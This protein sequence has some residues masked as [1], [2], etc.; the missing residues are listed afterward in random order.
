MGRKKKAPYEYRLRWDSIVYTP[1]ELRAVAYKYGRYWAEGTVSTTGEP[2]RLQLQ[3]DKSVLKS[4][5]EDLV[6][7]RVS[8]T[9]RDSHE[10]PTAEHWISCSLEGPGTIVAT[11]NGDPASL[12]SF[13]ETTRPAFNGLMLVILKADYRA[14]GTLRLKVT[15]DGLEEA[16]VKVRVDTE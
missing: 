10:V 5:G 13:S 7:V 12:L 2:E 14:R 1:G 15:A 16:E 9:D 6:F 4:D 11:D 3:P 8:I